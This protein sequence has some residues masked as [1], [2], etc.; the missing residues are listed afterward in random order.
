MDWTQLLGSREKA[1]RPDLD[2]TV[3][4]RPPHDR[5]STQGTVP[6]QGPESMRPDDADALSNR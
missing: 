5:S 2:E 1:E 4:N 6:K 3:I